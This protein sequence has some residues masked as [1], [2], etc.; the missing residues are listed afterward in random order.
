MYNIPYFKADDSKDVLEFM[1]EHS[2]ITLCGCDSK[3]RPVVTHVPILIE[4]TDGAV[5]LLGHMMKQTDHHK[6]FA[7]N[8]NVLAVFS[9]PHSYVSAS[10]YVNKQQASTWNY[11]TVHVK[12]ILSFLDNDSLLDILTRTTAKY[13]NNESS[14]SL[15]NRLSNDYVQKLM[16]A[17]IAFKIEV[18]E[19][20]H[21][22][23]L[24]QNKDKESYNNII[25]QLEQG[26]NDA[27]QVASLMKKRK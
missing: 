10:W 12:G 7:D 21:V 25:T 8:N 9:G 23:K 3:N 14:P 24:S 18:K 1:H 27:K 16:K 6:A 15:V 5:F 17:I 4:E 11:T 20:D 22:F 13:E 19:I 26:N 2:F